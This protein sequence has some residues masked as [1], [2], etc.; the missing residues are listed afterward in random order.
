MKWYLSIILFFCCLGAEA[1]YNNEW[2]DYSKTYYKFSV[3]KDGLVR[4]P[5]AVLQSVGLQNIPAEHFQLWRNGVQI[6]IYTSVSTGILGE[7]GYIE[8]WGEMNDGKVDRLLYRNVNEQLSDKWSLYTDTASYFLTVNPSGGNIRLTPTPNEV[9]GNTLPADQY[10]MYTYSKSFKNRINHGYAGIVGE[11]VYSSSYDKGEGYTSNDIRPPN[12]LN[13]TVNNLFPFAGGPDGT[14]FIS[15]FGN[16]NNDRNV[17]VQ[18]NNTTLVDVPM[19]SFYDTKQQVPLPASLISSGAAAVRIINTSAE[20]NDRMVVGKYELTYA[21]QFNFGNNT[22]F[23]FELEANPGGNYL[24]ITN[25]NHGNT[26]TLP[27]LYDLTNFRRYQA[28]KSQSGVL[29]FVLQ[30][31]LQKRKLVLVNERRSNLNVITT[32]APRN[33]VNYAA[34]DRQGNYLIISNTLLY[35]GNNGNP[36]EAYRQYRASTTGGGYNVQI[37]DIDQLIDQFAFGIKGHPFSVKNFIKYTTDVFSDRP[38]AV[39]L[40]G[41]GVSYVQARSNESNPLLERLNLV[42]T[43]GYPASDNLLAA[44]DNQTLP[45]VTIGRLSAVTPSEVEIYLNKVK[46]YEAVGRGAPHTVAGRAWMKN[47]VH[48][49]GG[50]DINLTK[51]IA[52]YMNGLKKTIEDTLVGGTVRSFSKTSAVASQL[53]SEELQ[54]MFANGIGILNYFGHSSSTTTEFNIDDPTAYE[55]KAKYP[56]FLVNGCLAGDI[57]NFEANRI[58]TITTLSERYTFAV[59]KGC[60]GFIASSHF[61]IVS[62]LNTYLEGLYRAFNTNYGNNIAEQLKQSFVYLLNKYPSDFFAR[63]H[64]EE[65]TLH[66]DPVIRLYQSDMPDYAVEEQYVDIPPVVSVTDN[67][68]QLKVTVFNLGKAEDDSVTIKVKRQLPDGATVEIL[69]KRMRIMYADSIIL[70]VP[71][72]PALEKGENRI[73]VEIDPENTAEEVT[74]FNNHAV[75]TFYIIEDLAF[76]VYPNNLSIIKDSQQKL[77][78]STAN[79]LRPMASYVME[80]DTTGSFSSSSKVSRTVT[81]TGGV[82]EFDPQFTY[83]DSTVYHWRVSLLPSEGNDYRWS[84]N[85]FMYKVNTEGYNQS[86]YHQ[87]LESAMERITL[88]SATGKWLFGTKNNTILV[89]NCIYQPGCAIT[90]DFVVSLNNEDLIQ[91]ACLGRSLVFN[92]IDGKTFKPWKNVDEN[93]NNLNLYGSASANC[94]PER[95][96]NFEFSYLTPASRKLM[97][98]F[99]DIIP[100]GAFVVIRSFDYHNPGSYSATWKA[101]EAVYGEGNSLYHKLKEVGF[102]EIDSL[103]DFRAWLLVY[104]KGVSAFQ[105]AYRIGSSFSDRLLVELNAQTPDSLG[106]ITSPKFGPAKEWKRVIWDGVSEETVST[107]NVTLEVIG[108]DRSNNEST[109]FTVDERIKDFDISNISAAQYPYLQLRMRTADSANL[110][111]YQ[112]YYWRILHDPVPEGALAPNLFFQSQDTI[113]AGEELKFAVAFKNVSPVP[114]DS[115]KFRFSLIDKNNFTHIIDS[116]RKKVLISGDTVRVEYTIKNTVDYQGLNTLIAYFNPDGDQPEYSVLNNFLYKSV[117]VRP[118]NVSPFLDV[119]FDGV[120][121][122]NNDIVSARP[123]I[124]I[125][126]KDD[127]RF[128]A[129]DDT[130]LLK[131]QVSFP[132]NSLRSFSFSNDTLRFTPST[133]SGGAGNNEATIEFNPEFLDDGTYEL[134]VSGRDKSGNKSGTT[135]YSVSFKVINKPMISNMFNYPNPFTTSTAF[136]FTLTGREVP[137]NI[138]IQILTI[139][140]KIVREITRQELGDIRIGRNITDFKWDG[141]DQ[142][143]QRL[144]NGVYL[145]RVITNL[146]GKSLEKYKTEGDTTDRFFNSGY[147]KMYLMR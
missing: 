122:L 51:Q 31:S 66:G 110:S 57:F 46:E 109:L 81:S 79:P 142:Y 41:K 86:D 14:F 4:I 115:L 52:G 26:D 83:R 69:T 133:S 68:F 94:G 3:G 129:L 140:G 139:T 119:T 121:I 98:D 40:I 73:T 131:V 75:K 124:L 125:K 13:E 120:H 134:I 42:P 58:G 117:Y 130:A 85:S 138:R 33:F 80:I 2:I 8:F 38:R 99:M 27:V 45:A 35:N 64:A 135:N 74:K 116:S 15:A 62:F 53:T 36:V 7:S 92:V 59:D 90:S 78:A 147:G 111:P 146:N 50:G 39:F 70:K 88:D 44:R 47:T 126:L 96:Y 25:F 107:D 106:I 22:N 72:N 34:A 67:S 61:G 1:Q 132:D 100:D 6:P 76:P 136:V 30:P 21:R 20:N 10:F 123:N 141:T 60:I 56:L 102:A 87:H 18:V 101:D 32:L 105:P 95:I 97:M 108:I 17:R 143:G 65:I 11:Y 28:D 63:L 104:K 16:A 43:F 55:N 24:R 93:G 145:Y 54:S 137:Q 37:Y 144:A 12:P 128:L 77:Y 29:Q 127:S 5:D 48:A 19:E 49:I 84:K 89:K 82:L 114:F 9:A 103:Y 118:D 91:S 112:L 113:D 71:I 23:V